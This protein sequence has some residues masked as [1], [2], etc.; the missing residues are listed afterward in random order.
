MGRGKENKGHNRLIVIL[1]GQSPSPYNNT[2]LNV[3][4]KVINTTIQLTR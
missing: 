1:G 4:S 3:A 2:T